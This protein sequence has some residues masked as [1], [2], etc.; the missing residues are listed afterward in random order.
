MPTTPRGQTP[1]AHFRPVNACFFVDDSLFK[2]HP[3][4]SECFFIYILIYSEITTLFPDFRPRMRALKTDSFFLDLNI[5]VYG[6]FNWRTARTHYF[7]NLKGGFFFYYFLCVSRFLFKFF[8]LL[9][10]YISFYQRIIVSLNY[11]VK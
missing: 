1:Q 4:Y 11:L 2:H 5:Y 10:I 6:V 9:K 7:R 8:T 3:F